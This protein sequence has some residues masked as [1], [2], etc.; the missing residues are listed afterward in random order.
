MVIGGRVRSVVRPCSNGPMRVLPSPS[1]GSLEAPGLSRH[2]QALLIIIP[3]IL[4]D[5]NAP[6]RLAIAPVSDPTEFPDLLLT[7]GVGAR[8]I[9]ALA[10]VAEVVHELPTASPIRLDFPSLTE[11]RTGFGVRR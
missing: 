2:Y 8:T 10:M 6:T 9:R 1:G 11:V 3:V 5:W 7:P 4:A